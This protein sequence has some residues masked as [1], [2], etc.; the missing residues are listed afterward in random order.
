ME[1]RQ[2]RTII[3]FKKDGRLVRST[4]TIHHFPSAAVGQ[5]MTFDHPI[6]SQCVTGTITKIHHV[7]FL[8]DEV[9]L[10]YIDVEVTS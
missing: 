3:E 5:T 10:T 7:V 4:S 1:T 2:F 6:T 9:P 8:G